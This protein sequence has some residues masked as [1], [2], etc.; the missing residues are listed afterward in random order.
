M[1]RPG[2]KSAGIVIPNNLLTEV[3]PPVLVFLVS[4]GLEDLVRREETLPSSD[5][6]RVPA[7]KG[8]K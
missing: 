6:K 1:K 5:I 8:N 4:V 7:K 3:W 2:I